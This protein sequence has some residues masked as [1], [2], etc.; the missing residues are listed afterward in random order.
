MYSIG[1]AK[2]DSSKMEDTRYRTI[3]KVSRNEA[4]EFGR[5]SSGGGPAGEGGPSWTP[6]LYFI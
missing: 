3:P 6:I 1:L 2:H 4:G 5:R